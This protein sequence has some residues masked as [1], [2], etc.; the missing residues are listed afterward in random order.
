[1]STADPS[2]P[3]LQLDPATAEFITGVASISVA[4]RDA[5]LMPSVG[6]AVGCL[7]SPDRREIIVLIDREQSA[8]I[9]ADIA[10]GSPIAAVFSLPATHRTVQIKGGRASLAP[11]T[12]TQRV[13]A[14]LHVD[15][16]VEHL[17]PLGYAE[18]PLRVLFSYTPEALLALR[19]APAAVFAQ[20]PG[21]RAGERVAG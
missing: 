3:G 9:A 14:R 12:P 8:Q 10:A 21:P 19:F 6:K 7:V 1:M 17:V 2:P 16:I 20:T 4:T 11:A 15:A 18:A 13:R 5:E